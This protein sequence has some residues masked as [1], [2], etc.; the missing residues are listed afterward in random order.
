MIAGSLA[1]RGGAIVAWTSSIPV[2]GCKSFLRRTNS[3]P[4]QAEEGVGRVTRL[5]LEIHIWVLSEF[6]YD[7]R[8]LKMS[9]VVCGG[10]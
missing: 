2:L 9:L 10:T 5:R 4:K 8:A 3:R 1:K 6:C 7:R